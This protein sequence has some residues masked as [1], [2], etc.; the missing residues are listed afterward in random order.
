MLCNFVINIKVIGTLKLKKK[1]YFSQLTVLQ[2]LKSFSC[3]FSNNVIYIYVVIVFMLYLQDG[4]EEK[5]NSKDKDS[6]STSES[7]SKY[8]LSYFTFVCTLS[9]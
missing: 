4:Q 9:F 2:V 3:F 6:G 5:E 8:I 1:K 7:V